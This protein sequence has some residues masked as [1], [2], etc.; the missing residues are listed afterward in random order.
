MIG[1][2]LK[3]SEPIS[4]IENSLEIKNSLQNYLFSNK[5]WSNNKFDKYS[6][7]QRQ[8][9]MDTSS[10]FLDNI[11]KFPKHHLREESFGTIYY[12]N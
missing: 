9:F 5:K 4:P 2:N 6:E 12:L 1:G 10:L 7:N 11:E 3:L 8:T